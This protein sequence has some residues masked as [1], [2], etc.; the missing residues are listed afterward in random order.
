MVTIEVDEEVYS[1]LKA[2]AEPFVDTPNTVLKRLLFQEPLTVNFL[3]KPISTNSNANRSP[4][5]KNFI[6]SETFVAS[7]LKK[8]GEKFRMRTPY[9]MMFESENHLIYFQNFNKSGTANLWYRLSKGS[10]NALRTTKKIALVCFTN[11]SEKIIYEIP[12]KDIDIQATKANWEKDFFEVNIDPA[13]SRWRELDWNIDGF[14]VR[15]NE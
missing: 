1:K 10:L 6:S 7:F 3:S 14:I 15:V 4:S 12:M 11:L 8:Y 2:L 13:N 5:G 9:R